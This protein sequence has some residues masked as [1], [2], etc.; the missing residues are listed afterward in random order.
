MLP[1]PLTELDRGGIGTV[2]RPLEYR[3][4]LESWQRRRVKRH[5][6]T[7]DTTTVKPYA[8][9]VTKP[10][11]SSRAVVM[12]LVRNDVVECA[13]DGRYVGSDPN[14]CDRSVGIQSPSADL[15]SSTRSVR[16]QVKPSS[17]R[18]KWP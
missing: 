17:S 7:A 9:P 6:P 16:S 2:A 13:I 18:P 4:K 11:R 8:D 5:D 12:P 3:S 1:D 10:K 15:R 14:R